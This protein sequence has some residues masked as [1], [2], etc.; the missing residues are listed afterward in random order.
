MLART[1]VQMC[2]EEEGPYGRRRSPSFC[3]SAGSVAE[4]DS[5]YK[6]MVECIFLAA[7]SN[8]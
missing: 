5:C 6:K 3:S 7:K 2:R 1:L 4:V 8:I